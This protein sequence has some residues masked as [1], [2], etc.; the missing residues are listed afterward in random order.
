MLIMSMRERQVTKKGCPAQGNLLHSKG[1]PRP[2][3]PLPQLWRSDREEAKER[4]YFL[5]SWFFSIQT[6]SVFSS[7]SSFS[8]SLQQ[9]AK[10]ETRQYMVKRMERHDRAMSPPEQP[11][12]KQRYRKA[13]FASAE[14]R[15]NGRRKRVRICSIV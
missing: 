14:D 4:G 2:V 15:K 9:L 3:P 12:S 6:V 11:S 1:T 5:V 13:P 10:A 8:F 7:C